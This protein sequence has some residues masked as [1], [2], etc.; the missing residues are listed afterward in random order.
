MQKHSYYLSKY[1]SQLGIYVDVYFPTA[2]GSDHTRLIRLY[3]GEEAVFIRF[4]PVEAPASYAFPGHYLLECYMYSRKVSKLLSD[5]RSYDIIYIQGFSGWHLL[6]S[7]GFDRSTLTV[8]NFHGLNMFQKVKG[9]RA[10][11]EGMMFKPIVTRLLKRADFVQSLGGRLTD[12]LI[13]AGVDRERIVEIGIGISETW[14]EGRRRDDQIQPL[15]TFIF[16]GR[17]DYQKGISELYETLLGIVREHR[18]IFHFVGPFPK[19][20]QIDNDRIVYHGLIEEEERIIALLDSADFLVLPSYSEGMPTVVLE[21][22]SRRCAVIATDVGAM[23]QLVSSR[24]GTLIRQQEPDDLRRALL[25]AIHLPASELARK[26][27]ASFERVSKHFTW[28]RVAGTTAAFFYEIT[29]SVNS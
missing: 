24:N 28:N 25:D 12:L 18:F 3:T 4:F 26:K 15:R 17:F 23:A 19:E 21:A 27:E 5:N 9:V 8:I 22:M 29:K 11:L 16:V 6:T 10:R 20:K 1:L 14:L 7:A 13:S 2:A